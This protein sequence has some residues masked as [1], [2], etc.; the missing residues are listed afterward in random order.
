MW[1]CDECIDCD[2][3]VD[4]NEHDCIYRLHNGH[5]DLSEIEDLPEGYNIPYPTKDSAYI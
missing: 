1:Y 3:M 4:D 5:G 2:E